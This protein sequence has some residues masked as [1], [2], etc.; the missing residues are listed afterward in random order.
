MMNI[1]NDGIENTATATESN[2][3]AIEQVDLRD[4]DNAEYEAAFAAELAAEGLE[5]SD[6][7]ELEEGE[8]E[9]MRGEH[10]KGESEVDL[11]VEAI[12][13]P[14]EEAPM[15]TEAPAATDTKDKTPPAY[16]A[17]VAAVAAHA[18]ALGLH[19]KEQKGFFQIYSETGHKLYVAKQGKGVSRID[20][21]MPRSILVV[22]GQDLSLPLSKPNGRIACHVDPSVES[23][24][25][26]LEV[27]ASYKTQI[28]APRK[29]AAKPVAGV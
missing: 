25:R 20:T 23:V 29:P 1:D 2:H 8:G 3:S 18:A 10:Y 11:D 12:A 24:N 26:A 9:D 17:F 27:L 6:G 5:A 19:V 7:S 21:T 16:L 22:N 15:V 14:A 13:G 4:Q 28:P